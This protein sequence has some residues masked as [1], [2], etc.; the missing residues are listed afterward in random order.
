MNDVAD[1]A[2]PLLRTLAP[3][4]RDLER[5]LQVCIDAERRYEF[6]L[7]RKAA[8]TGIAADLKRK[9]DD[10]D[11]D[12]PLLVV[13][14]MGG[15]GVGKSTLLN[16]LAGASIAQASFQRPTTRDPVVYYHESVR[17]ER[18]D[19]AL[20]GCRLQPHDRDA[21]RD[22]IIVDTPDLDSNDL[23]NRETLKAVLP[24][25]D[26]VLYVGSQEKYH[27]QLGWE[28]FREQRHRRAFAFVLN[29][30]DRCLQTN[31]SGLRPDEDLLRDLRAEGFESP[32]LFRTSAQRWLDS[33]NG[34]PQ[35][36]LPAGEQFKELVEW[37]E[38]RL[39]GLEI[40]AVKA[41]GVG[42]LLTQFERELQ[43]ATPPNLV[44]IASATQG[45]WE[46]TLDEKSAGDTEVL[47]GTLDPHQSEIELH[48][49][50]QGQSRFWGLMRGYLKLFSSAKGA[51]NI[52]RDKLTIFP[53]RTEPEAPS[54]T[55]TWNVSSFTQQCLTEAGERFLDQRTRDLIARLQ[56]I[57]V[58][59][60]FPI[61]LLER[62]CTEAGKLDW[63]HRYE[64]SLRDALQ[65]AE[66]VWTKPT[67]PRRWLQTAIVHTA[68]LLPNIV[69]I[70]GYLLLMYRY[71]VGGYMPQ[72]FDVL[73]PLIMT[74][75]SMILLQVSIVLLL[76]MRWSSIRSEFRRQL[77]R[78]LTAL[79]REIYLPIPAEVAAALEQERAQIEQLRSDVR[80]VATWLEQRQ[81]AANVTRLYGASAPSTLPAHPG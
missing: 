62:P 44:S 5:K 21:L 77:E 73:L 1:T 78:R 10:L 19:P 11:G 58:E 72:L 20:R 61:R 50:V 2:A 56:N 66:Q 52:L 30:W 36:E 45:R 40:E 65:E 7:I 12:R 48:F 41:R 76:P 37:L 75:I 67:G 43:G 47:L 64:H 33:R 31:A 39:T 81:Q 34:A 28:L 14:L 57:A 15:T 70:A 26:I 17:P 63:R 80:Q 6:D 27:D 29:K 4:L 53:K 3:L 13:M 22:K 60:S 69:L 23:A 54:T 46:K 79:L 42:Q 55:G 8:L 25:A 35:A 71:F 24:V 51:G 32:L 38:H 74:L 49:S 18:L 16:A 9:S 68:N 59:C